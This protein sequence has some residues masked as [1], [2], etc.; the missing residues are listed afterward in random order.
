MEVKRLQKYSIYGHRV[1]HKALPSSARNRQDIGFDGVILSA[2]A[3]S[4]RIQ[5]LQGWQP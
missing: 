3:P 5:H 2:H 1:L 4:L